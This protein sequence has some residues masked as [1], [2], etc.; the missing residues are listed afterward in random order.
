[1]LDHIKIFQTIRTLCQILESQNNF[2]LK[3]RSGI[4]QFNLNECDTDFYRINKMQTKTTATLKKLSPT[5][6]HE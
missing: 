6:R 4:C 2:R 5:Q 1:M 3:N